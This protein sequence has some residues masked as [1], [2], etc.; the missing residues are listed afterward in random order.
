MEI[1]ICGSRKV[2]FVADDGNTI[3]GTT[4]YYLYEDSNVS[5]YAPDRVFVRDGSYNPFTVGKSYKVEYNRRGKIDIAK[6]ELI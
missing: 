3:T 4:Y 2:S 6:A 1:S 5:G